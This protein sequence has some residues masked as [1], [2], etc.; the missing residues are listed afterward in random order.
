MYDLDGTLVDTSGEIAQ[1]VNATLIQYHFEPVTELQVIN[2]IGHGTAWLMQQAWPDKRDIAS[3]VTWGNIMQVF[4]QHYNDKVGSTSK[5][6]SGVIETLIKLK[7]QG[8]KQAVITNK[9]EPYTSR[10][11]NQHAMQDFFDLVI[12]GNTLAYKKPSA[13]VV[14]HCLRTL[15]V[16]KQ[17]S[18]F[19]GD[20]EIDMATAKNAGVTC[21]LV[22]YGYNAGKDITASN[23]DKIIQSIE[24]VPQFFQNLNAIKF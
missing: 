6:Y 11:L 17:E 14:K 20:S 5:P 13:E 23:P 21:W 3:S 22:P 8:I 1:A 24:E 16:N 19:V 2:W 4:M 9:E 7:K 12:S 15:E 18:L 10:I